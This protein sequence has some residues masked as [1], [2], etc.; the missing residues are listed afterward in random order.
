[1]P[2][3]WIPAL[4]L[5]LSE[6]KQTM[7]IPGKTVR[8][9]IDNLELEYPGI[10]ARLMDD[11]RLR[12]SISVMVDGVISQEKLRHKLDESSEVHFIPAISGGMGQKR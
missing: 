11:D 8:Q 4:L 6:G 2:K 3:V 10:R 1:M 12:P 7:D 9:V 5:P